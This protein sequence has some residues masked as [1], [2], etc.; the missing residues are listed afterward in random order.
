MSH[1]IFISENVTSGALCDQTLPLIVPEAFAMLRT[2]IEEFH[3]VG[4]IPY[5]TLDWR[6]KPLST[7]LPPKT[8]VYYIND[9]NTFLER[10]RTTAQQTD[11]SLLVAPEIQNAMGVCNKILNEVSSNFLGSDEKIT[12]FLI[13]KLFAGQFF[14]KQRLPAPKS[15]NVENPSQAHDCFSYF[16]FPS[17]LVVK[18]RQGA[19][20]DGVRLITSERQLKVAISELVP[21]HG[22][23]VVQE[24]IPGVAASVS[25]IVEENKVLFLSLNSQELSFDELK[26]EAEYKG[27]K[28]PFDH[29][30]KDLAFELTEAFVKTMPGLRGFIGLD[31]ILVDEKATLI[32]V[33]LRPTT[34]IIALARIGNFNLAEFVLTAKDRD[35]YEFKTLNYAEFG[36]VELECSTITQNDLLEF[37]H[38]PG[39][40]APPFKI[41]DVS[42][43]IAIVRG[44]GSSPESAHSQFQ[45][46]KLELQN[47]CS[48]KQS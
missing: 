1:K 46:V 6:L 11:L 47:Q 18:P 27:G 7:I 4:Y 48:S 25:L 5:T 34:P 37:V 12:A 44:I 17:Q 28:T 29:K 14:Q 40:V 13:D 15:I 38:L 30:A 10:F 8:C 31:M 20:A 42:K 36:K 35:P 24:Y 22:P 16:N 21:L 41:K 23:L 33:N 43:S 2:L 45:K 39:V 3:S 9:P 19:G 26:I 32:E